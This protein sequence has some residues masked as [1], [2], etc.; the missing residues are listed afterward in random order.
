[1][2]EDGAAFGRACAPAARPYGSEPMAPP[3]RNV[4]LVIDDN[5]ANRALAQATL[6]DEGYH[7]LLA[8]S[9]EAG[10]AAFLADQP[11][12]VLL[13]IQMPGMDGVTACRR[14]RELPGGADVPIVFLTAQRD[15]DTFDRAQV[16]GGDDFL[17]KPFRPAE[18]VLRIEAA[19]KLHQISIERNE[20]IELLRRQRD[21]VMRLQ[22]QREQ[23]IAFLVHD[24]KNPV[25]A[26][27]LNSELIGRD[28]AISPR[29]LAAAA[30]IT[31]DSESL[32]RMIMNLLDLS[33]ADEGRLVPVREPIEIAALAAEIA[34][35]M[36]ARARS[37]EIEIITDVA[38]RT[39]HA[40][41]D[42]V[43]RVLENLIDNA[44]RHAP[45]ETQVRISSAAHGAGVEL[46]VADAGPG[47]PPAL[48]ERVFERFVQGDAGPRGSRG[49]GLA[50]CKLAI[51]AHGGSIWIEDAN[52]GA[53]FCVRL[54]TAA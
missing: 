36:A 14:I 13:D 54:D 11:D 22:L 17:T 23:L 31:S 52:P 6:E 34:G 5:A 16:A 53:I 10:I 26:I 12:C 15:V 51:E 47:V 25:H 41:P 21:D 18:L 7:V 46:R 4:V 39:L 3:R 30:R 38:P 42:L 20:L 28:Q 29:S 45:A 1:M 27:K 2:T 49:L 32:L 44:I 50:F 8:A 24:L 40:D 43:R 9:G 37:A 33:K 48:R 35:A 19:M